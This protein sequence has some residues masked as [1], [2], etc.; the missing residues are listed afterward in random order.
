MS[1]SRFLLVFYCDATKFIFSLVSLV[2]FLLVSTDMREYVCVSGFRFVFIL[3]GS[4]KTILF[5]LKPCV[6]GSFKAVLPTD[7]GRINQF[8]CSTP[9]V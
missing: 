5:C 4:G 3:S 8:N 2:L 6:C 9:H 1:K 7:D